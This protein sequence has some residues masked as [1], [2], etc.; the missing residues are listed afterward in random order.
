M[1]EQSTSDLISPRKPEPDIQLKPSFRDS[2]LGRSFFYLTTTGTGRYQLAFALLVVAAFAMRLWELSGRTMHYDE[3]IH[4]YYSWRLSNMEGYIHSPWMHGPFQIE[5]V[6][7]FL[8]LLG[9]TDFVARLAYVCFGALLVAL[10]FFFKAHLGR[11][12]ALITGLMLTLSP[13]LLY[14]SRFG[15]NDII[16]AVLAASLFIL[17][18]RYIHNPRNRYLYLV[19]GA[20]AIAF[21]TKETAYI[22]TLIFGALALLLAFP[23]SSL[24]RS[25]G[26]EPAPPDAEY[27]GAGNLPDSS[28]PESSTASRGAPFQGLPHG[29][30][31][32]I[33]AGLRLAQSLKRWSTA[34]VRS[35]LCNPAG[36]FLVLLITL[37][38][39]QWSAGVELLRSVALSLVDW[40][41]GPTRATAIEDSLGI[42][43]VGRE[44][45][46][47]GIV[48]APIWGSPFVQLPLETVPAWIP[49][50]ATFLLIG[51]CILAGWKL[52]SPWLRRWA[53]VLLPVASAYS[54]ALFLARPIGAGLDQLFAVILL[55][56]C[57]ATFLYF[58][59]PW[60]HSFVLL[61]FPLLTSL[62]YCT[63]FL[64]VVKVDAVLLKTLPDGIQVASSGNSVPL[65]FLIAGGIL[66]VTAAAS[67][68]LGLLWRGGV[69]LAC[70]GI[71]YAIWATLFTTFF[72]NPAGLF[73]GIWQ[74]MGYW[75]AQQEV[76]RG[77]Q[78]WYYYFVGMSVYEF[79]PTIFGIVA[80]I[81]FIR[82]R[83]RLGMALAFWAG[84]NLLAYT[85]ASEKM[86]WLLVN[87]TLPFIF[88]AGKFL[89]EMVEKVR[90]PS[91]LS[92]A[93][94][95]LTYLVL[96]VPT[97]VLAGLLFLGVALTDAD[98]TPSLAEGGVLCG[99][100]ALALLAAW[101]LRTATGQERPPLIGLGLAI[102]LLVFT[103]WVA[104]QAAYT[105]DD[106]RM[107]ILVY[108]Q[109][110]ADLRDSHRELEEDQFELQD[111]TPQ[112]PTVKVDYDVWYPFQ[113]YVRHREKEGQLSFACFR[114][115]DGDGGCNAID[116]NT[117]G[118]ALL[119]ASHHRG[120]KPGVLTSYED[121]GPRRNLLWFPETYRRPGENRQDESILHEV[122]Q[123]LAFFR[124]SAGS[125]EQWNK[126]LNYLVGRQMESDWFN[127]EYYTYLRREQAVGGA[128]N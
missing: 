113:W 47:Q 101:L 39:P 36:G 112:S 70:A 91:V 103:G 98:L 79:L 128:A 92:G 83:D 15:R 73:S 8:R 38:L 19:S 126:I 106:S 29:Q 64:P 94:S 57:I 63:L 121:L 27:P 109:G 25:V 86:P 32:R 116:G 10:P 55:A 26:P 74:G 81:A 120:S 68:A 100:V 93:R 21:A 30:A 111:L 31:R 122:R 104:Y 127:S 97:T 20:L 108:A 77:N 87:I 80:A 61:F 85:I 69:W 78:P 3:A 58:R 90:W 45:V 43:L 16:M 34:A 51:L 65:N 41:L 37:T 99:V 9:D 23:Y 115:A 14:F 75:I 118:Q 60:K 124:D 62:V 123:D 107:E 117:E 46:S 22:I 84:I 42:T 56:G 82:R 17:L 89:G 49:G 110:S 54:M 28:G 72:T 105:Y 24:K 44:G 53:A 33:P 50:T 4:L 13:S 18:W 119:V 52:Y 59:I 88:L 102:G 7:L 114:D 12:G 71:F 67:L 125:R 2:W 6:A 76:A 95:T 40:T 5:L 96:A 11:A 1:N 66:L 35:T 48:G